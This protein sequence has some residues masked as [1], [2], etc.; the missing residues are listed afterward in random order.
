MM[1]SVKAHYNG[2]QIVMDEDIGLA[3]GQELII[4]LLNIKPKK[5]KPEI[6]LD[7]YIGRGE[8]MFNRDAQDYVKELR[9]NDRI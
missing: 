8:K 1:T 6:D 9:S 4:T 5:K 3:E 2:S 7:R